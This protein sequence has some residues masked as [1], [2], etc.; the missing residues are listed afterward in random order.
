MG[1][2]E[3]ILAEFDHEM[4]GVRKTLERVPA[5]KFEWRPHPRSG[6]MGWLASHLATLPGW[7]VDVIGK[8]GME[9]AREGKPPSGPPK[10]K[11]QQ[12]VLETFDKKREAAHAAIA[13]AS[14]EHLMK[15]WRLTFMGKEIFNLPRIAVLRS[16][17]ISHMI[18]HRA[19][20]G[21][22][23][24][25]NDLPVPSLYGPSADEPV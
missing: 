1:A 15:M 7:A 21:V 19:Q 22:Y 18:H 9:I 16:Y 2:A 25:L 14:D 17:L 11:T 24:R 12:E 5:E 6:T 8:D 13:G 20:L 4:A 10:M 3:G 23:L